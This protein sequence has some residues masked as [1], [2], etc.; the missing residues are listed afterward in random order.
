MTMASMTGLHNRLSSCHNRAVRTEA[1][2]RILVGTRLA[3]DAVNAQT[4]PVAVA[5]IAVA[6]GCGGHIFHRNRRCVVVMLRRLPAQPCFC[7]RCCGFMVVR[8]AFV[9]VPLALAD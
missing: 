5:L 8:F 3:Y 4:W 1:R 9:H 2:V 6:S 7:C